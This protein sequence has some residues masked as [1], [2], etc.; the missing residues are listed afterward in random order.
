MRSYEQVKID[1]A[2]FQ[3]KKNLSKAKQSA[4]NLN[5]VIPVHWHAIQSGDSLA[6][7]HIPESQVID[8]IKV[9]NEDYATTGFSFKL[10]SANY[11]TNATWFEAAGPDTDYPERVYQTEMK[12]KLHQGNATTLN[13]YCHWMNLY[14][15]FSESCDDDGD[16]VDDTPAQL[17]S[18]KGCPTVAPDSC[19][20]RP[21]RDPIHNYMDYSS[22]ICL[23]EFTRGQIRRMQ[24]S[25]I[26]FRID[27]A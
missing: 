10:E 23:T 22:D 13:I 24:E 9:L 19:P 7:G 17:N 8:S 25:F 15:T 1:E 18:T 27:S 20:G 2:S 12:G 14:H 21:G 6:E 4:L 16:F 11:V 5:V 26:S 3:E